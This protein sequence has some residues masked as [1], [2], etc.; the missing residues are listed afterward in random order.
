MKNKRNTY[1]LLVLVLVVWG[2]IGYRIFSSLGT[3]KNAEL[4]KNIAVNFNPTAIKKQDT[5][6]ISSYDRDPF[7]GTFKRKKIPV[8]RKS[9]SVKKEIQWPTIRYSGLIDNTN[10][11]KQIYFVFV[12]NVQYLMKLKDEM[13]GVKLLKATNDEI[14]VRFNKQTKKIALNQ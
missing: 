4:S 7:L 13:E 12:N 9:I 11:D 10:T 8:K 5:F 14:T 6:T 1:F 2:M 3:D